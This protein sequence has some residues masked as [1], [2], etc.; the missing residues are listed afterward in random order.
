MP[1]MHILR[2]SS[3]NMEVTKQKK[4]LKVQ[5]SGEQDLR[6]SRIRTRNIAFILNGN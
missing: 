1:K 6:Y 4:Q 2:N 5:T 3:I